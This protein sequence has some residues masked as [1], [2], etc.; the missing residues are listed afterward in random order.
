MAVRNIARIKRDVLKQEG[1]VFDKIPSE[2]QA[3]RQWLLWRLEERDGRTTKVPYQPNG[4]H[5]ERRPNRIL[6]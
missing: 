5:A 4:R 6:E 2:L 3:L 1:K